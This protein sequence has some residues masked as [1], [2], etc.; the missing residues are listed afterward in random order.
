[1]IVFA[2]LLVYRGCGHESSLQWWSSY[3]IAY[4]TPTIGE[5]GTCKYVA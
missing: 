1:V 5:V 4:F 2:V 3:V